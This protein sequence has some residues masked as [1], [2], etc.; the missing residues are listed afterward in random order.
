LGLLCLYHYQSARGKFQ[1]FFLSTLAGWSHSRRFRDHI[2]LKKRYFGYWMLA[3]FSFSLGSSIN[4]REQLK[5]TT[6]K[7]FLT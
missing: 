2:I 6:F 3:I 1:D 7:I 5:Q 4:K